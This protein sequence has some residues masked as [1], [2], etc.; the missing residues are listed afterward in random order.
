VVQ[1]AV[2]LVNTEGLEALT[3]S[4]LA[5]QLGIQTPSLYNHV[6]G[7]SGLYRELA[8]LDVRRLGERLGNAAIGKSGAQAV[9]AVAQAYRSYI[10]ENA[11]LYHAGLRQRRYRVPGDAEMEG[12][13]DRVVEIA[14]AVVASFGLAGEDGLHAVRGLRSLVHGFAIL[15]AAGGFGLPLDL[16]ES[17]HRLVETLIRGMRESE[18][19]STKNR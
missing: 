6:A 19:G 13:E 14:L 5:G 4:R 9:Q 11:G 8:L 15:E 18:Y 17:F 1:A 2:D 12:A 3:L 16:D 7:L 10:K